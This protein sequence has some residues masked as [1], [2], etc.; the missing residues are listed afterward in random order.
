MG[1]ATILLFGNTVYAIL[2]QQELKR[3][4]PLGYVTSL[5]LAL[6]GLVSIITLWIGYNSKLI[7]GDMPL[8][9]FV[10]AI[11]LVCFLVCFILCLISIK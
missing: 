5:I 8:S 10:F 6:C 11:A 7:I 3:N 4:G 2:G 9:I 1:L